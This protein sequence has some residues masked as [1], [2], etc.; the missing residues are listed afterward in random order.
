MSRRLSGLVFL[1]GGLL[2]ATAAGCGDPAEGDDGT[3]AGGGGQVLG[4]VFGGTSDTG[5]TGSEDAGAS[6]DSGAE[7]TGS[8]TVDAGSADTGGDE[9]PGQAYCPCQQ[10][11][12]CD[13]GICIATASGKVCAAKCVDG[14]AK[15]GFV[16][17]PFA[18]GGGDNVQICLPTWDWACDPCTKSEQCQRVGLES[19]VCVDHGGNGGFCGIP[20]QNEK[21][22]PPDYACMAVQ[23]V[24]G[25]ASKQCVPKQPVGSTQPGPGTC[26]CSDTAKKKKLATTCVISHKGTDG[27]V[28]A[29]CPG[30][31]T[32]TKDGLTKCIGPPPTSETCDG[33][34]NDCDGKTDENV[35]DDNNACTADACDPS[36]ATGGKDGCKHNKLDSA[37]DAD[38]SVCT[39]KDTC[40]DGVCVPG[41]AKNCDDAN[42]CTLDACDPASGCTKT[43]DDGKTC[44]GDGNPCTVGDICKAGACVIGKPKNCASNDPC[45]LAKCSPATGKCLFST[46]SDKTPC[47]DANAC[48]SGDACDQGFCKGGA[49]SCND[50][51]PCT[52]DSCS[53]KSG[54]VH[55]SSGAGCDDGNKCTKSDVCKGA[56]CVGLPVSATSCSDGNPCTTDACNPAKGCVNVQKDGLP[57]DDGDACTANDACKSGQCKAGSFTCA[58]K[59]DADC[60][61]KDDGNLCNGVLRCDKNGA[62][63]AC[64]L[65]PSTIVVCKKPAGLC[66]SVG[67]APKTGVCVTAAHKPGTSCDDGNACTVGDACAGTNA[68]DAS[69]KPGAKRVCDDGNVCTVD[70]CA[71]KS[72]CATKLDGAYSATCY[73]GPKKSDGVGTCK[74]GKRT[75]KN[76]ATLGP[77]V[78]EVTP[79][80][81]ELCDGQDDDCDG[82][83]DT[84]CGTA[85][86]SVAQRPGSVSGSAGNTTLHV[87]VG[88]SVAG[89]SDGGSSRSIDW[90]WHRFIAMLKGK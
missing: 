70:S 34:D 50:N 30:T 66:L 33:L 55:K 36:A 18:V 11:D 3:D 67:C 31:R 45:V 21:V 25:A 63:P 51:N 72:G 85:G 58:C 28:T 23:S 68:T 42:P 65:D 12:E 54:C 22:C 29:T 62:Q 15:A 43:I 44:D 57:C 81:V 83:T 10:N 75:C 1:L 8:V 16:C 7:D 76:D 53:D 69:C 59:V 48:T 20:C 84:G 80:K 78:G 24:E 49:I 4:D 77:C 47:D 35:C 64:K 2:V 5:T 60:V 9:C 41:K 56:T 89:R 52:T 61:A 26:T 19:A 73:S 13:T 32:C 87:R 40:T 46:K 37:C 14:C 17:S 88:G 6:L 39:E 71:P 27:K 74:A 90:G 86:W 38:G 82:K 79:A